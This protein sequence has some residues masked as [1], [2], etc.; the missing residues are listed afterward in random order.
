MSKAIGVS[1]NIVGNIGDCKVNTEAYNVNLFTV[2]VTATDSC[3]G[4]I[5]A[6]NQMFD[7]GWII[8]GTIVA[9]FFFF[10]HGLYR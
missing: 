10:I 7:S 6:Q 4:Q 5:I 2:E 9:I 3:T 8:F 1:E